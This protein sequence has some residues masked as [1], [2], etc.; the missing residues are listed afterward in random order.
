LSDT[1]KQILKSCTS[2]IEEVNFPHYTSGII[3]HLAGKL[4][5]SLFVLLIF[6][7]SYF[8][9]NQSVLPK[10]KGCAT[11][12]VSSFFR[13][14]RTISVYEQRPIDGGKEKT[15]MFGQQEGRRLAAGSWEAKNGIQ[16]S[17]GSS[18]EPGSRTTTGIKRRP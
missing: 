5:V 3:Y 7:R 6:V 2:Q 15:M 9:L 17:G 16:A 1:S 14:S 18:G 11:E 8:S 10:R 13:N 4:A 12:R